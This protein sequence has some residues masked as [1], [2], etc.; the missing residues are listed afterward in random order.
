MSLTDPHACA[1]ARLVPAISL[2]LAQCRPREMAGTSPAMTTKLVS[3]AK[4]MEAAGG[5][6]LFYC[7]INGAFERSHALTAWTRPPTSVT[8]GDVLVN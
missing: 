7:I 8:G 1:I 3:F 4:P 2:A 5:G 6:L